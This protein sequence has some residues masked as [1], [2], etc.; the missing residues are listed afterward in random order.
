MIDNKQFAKWFYALQMAKGR[1]VDENMML[2]WYDFLKNYPANKVE[3]AFMRC[4]MSVD[5]FPNVGKIIE[6]IKGKAEVAAIERW[7]EV[8]ICATNGR[9]HV[10]KLVM[11]AVQAIGG[12]EKIGYCENDYQMGSMMRRF[13]EIY[14]NKFEE[15]RNLPE[16]ESKQNRQINAPVKEALK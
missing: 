5:G 12:M 7:G 2:V 9:D 16:I 1:A 4:A 14:A 8:L 15:A 3:R 13:I 10:D 11:K 6:A